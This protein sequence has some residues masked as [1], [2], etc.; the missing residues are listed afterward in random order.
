MIRDEARANWDVASRK[1]FWNQILGNLGGAQPQLLDFNQ[2]AQTLHLRTQMYRGLQVVPLAKIVGSVGRYKDFTGAFLPV[3]QDMGERWRRVA[4]LYLDPTGS[5]APPVELYKVGDSYFVKDGN[6]R[7]SVANQLGM[8]DIE[9]YVWEYEV[10]VEDPAPSADIDSLL[11]ETE[12]QQFLAE[13]HLDDLIPHHDI[14]LTEPGGYPELLTQI[15]HY[16]D[17]LA[18]IDGHPVSFEEAV[19][20]WYDMVYEVAVQIIEQA[21]VL[22]L[23]PDRTVADFFVWISRYQENLKERYGQRPRLED[24]ARKIPRQRRPSLLARLWQFILRLLRLIL[25]GG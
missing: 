18:R 1:A 17:V 2:V 23:F 11:L 4:T 7:V 14:R 3:S 19:K 5:G 20:A 13:T 24:L 16:Q 15:V 8:E 12:R 6:H 21:G 9:A 22:E 10:P 25:V